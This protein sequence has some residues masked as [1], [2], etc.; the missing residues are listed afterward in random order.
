MIDNGVACPSIGLD[1][2]GIGLRVPLG[3][4]LGTGIRMSSGEPGIILGSRPGMWILFAS[5]WY[6]A[7]MI[8]MISSRGNLSLGMSMALQC[9]R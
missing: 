6:A 7:G 3:G 9:I 2:P 1:I 5:F 8:S 4:M